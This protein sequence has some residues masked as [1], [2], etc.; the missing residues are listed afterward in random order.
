M[1]Q[2]K[3]AKILLENGGKSVRKAMKEAGYSDTMADNP[4][5]LTNTKSWQELMDEY[6]PEDEIAKKHKELLNAAELTAY[7]YAVKGEKDELPDRE[8]IKAAI[9]SVPG[10]R[11]IHW[12]EHWDGSLTVHFQAPDNRTRK[13]ALDMAIKLRGKYAAEKFEVTDPIA[14]LSNAELAAKIAGL[15]AHLLKKKPAS[16]S[17]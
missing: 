13:D 1:R 15:K 4:Q 6:L 9:E 14:K 17:K 7:H 8:D 11:V 3:A 12:Q 2:R 10:C 5:K 16:G